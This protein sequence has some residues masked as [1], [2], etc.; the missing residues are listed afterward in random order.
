MRTGSYF[1][2]GHHG[3][4]DIWM[5]PTID[6]Q[7]GRLY[8]ATG[9]PGSDLDPRVRLGRDLWTNSIVALDAKTG[10]QVWGYQLEHSRRL[11]PGLGLAARPLPDTVRP[12]G[13]RGEQG[14]LLARGRRRERQAADHSGPVRLPAPGRREAGRT[15]RRLVAGAHRRLGM[16]AGALQPTDRARLHLRR[17]CAVPEQGAEEGTHV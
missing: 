3:G 4:G 5:N 6:P 14:R 2:N 15:G 10:K 1:K 8:V 13:R 7:T 16:V 12:R 11:G 17:Q 9:N